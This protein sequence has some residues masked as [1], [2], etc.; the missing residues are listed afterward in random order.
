MTKFLKCKY[1]IIFQ[2]SKKKIY[3][4]TIFYSILN[5][6][7]DFYLHYHEKYNYKTCKIKLYCFKT[8]NKY[9]K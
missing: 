5:K 6:I 8:C 4:N 3:N 7:Y 9:E 1:N 2:S